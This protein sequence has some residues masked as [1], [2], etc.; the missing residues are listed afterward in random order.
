MLTLGDGEEGLVIADI[1]RAG[2]AN[3]EITDKIPSKGQQ[4]YVFPPHILI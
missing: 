1:G 3:D 2:L 4:M